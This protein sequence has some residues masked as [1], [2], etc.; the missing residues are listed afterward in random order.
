MLVWISSPKQPAGSQAIIAKSQMP[1]ENP[2][3]LGAEM[4]T[5]L[6]LG[7]HPA[8]IVWMREPLFYQPRAGRVCPPDAFMP[9]EALNIWP[10]L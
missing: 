9:R 7:H 10:K 5:R 2:A 8:T 6:V 1:E 4:P 3:L